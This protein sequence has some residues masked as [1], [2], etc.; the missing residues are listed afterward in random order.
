M[1]FHTLPASTFTQSESL[2]MFY[3]TQNNTTEIFEICAKQEF[4]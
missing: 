2:G 4:S 1:C 3:V